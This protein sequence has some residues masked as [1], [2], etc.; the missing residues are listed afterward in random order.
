LLRE[1]GDSMPTSE[2]QRLRA[3]IAALKAELAEPAWVGQFK[4]ALDQASTYLDAAFSGMNAIISQSQKN[5]EIEIENEYKKRLDAINANI[6]D[7]TE[8]Q[9]AVNALEAEFNIK[10]T[11]AKRAAA[12]QQKAIALMEAVVNTAR[13]VTEAL[14]NFI[15]A[16]LVGAMGAVQIALIA[17]QP[18]PLA[19]GAVFDKPTRFATE[20]GGLYVAG[21]A[22]TE[23]LVPD[24][25]LREIMRQELK[26]TG[27]GRQ[28]PRTLQ[29]NINGRKI[30]EAL[31]PELADLGVKGRMT[32][33]IAGLV[34]SES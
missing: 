19:K 33:D 9:N 7:E 10:R 14:P 13:A 24:K 27:A 2:V 20:G 21:E 25:K 18:I 30:A 16:A 26:R 8:R 29:I 12:K 22:G 15:L 11:S 32:Y 3:E 34:R 5:R 6:S 23:L 4:A 31:L 1:F 28:S 17:R